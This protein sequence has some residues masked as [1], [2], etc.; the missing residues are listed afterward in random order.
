MIH[1]RLVP[2]VFLLLAGLLLAGCGGGEATPPATE[3]AATAAPAD[4]TTPEE[5]STDT[6]A[7]SAAGA[8]VSP[9]ATPDS[10][11]A[12]PIVA[13]PLPTP[14]EQPEPTGETGSIMGRI[15]VVRPEGEIPVADII[16][17]LAEVIYDDSGV[18]VMSGYDASTTV[19]VPTDPYG[20]FV[21]N[22]V[23]P[24]AYTL[25]LDSIIRQYQL[26][27]EATRSTIIVDVTAGE[28][29]DLGTLE[30]TSLPLPGLQ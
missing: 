11:L 23:T 26:K 29:T 22:G 18:A 28:V 1:F 4:E 17:G 15:L 21:M 30:Y 25:I 20:R 14:V 5:I 8:A 13:S 6:S 12:V 10:P 27:D 2:L 3:A 7:E 9:L 19:R 16:I 24:G